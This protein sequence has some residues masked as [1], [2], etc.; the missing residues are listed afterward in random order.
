MRFYILKFLYNS[1]IINDIKY[2]FSMKK[3]S[4]NSEISD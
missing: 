3:K 1:F 2:F 4:D